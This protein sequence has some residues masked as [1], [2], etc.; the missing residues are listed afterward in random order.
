MTTTRSNLRTGG[1]RPSRRQASRLTTG[2]IALAMAVATVSGSPAGA[3]APV[4]GRAPLMQASAAARVLAAAAPPVG[5]LA[6]S[7]CDRSGATVSCHLWAKPGTTQ[8]LGQPLPIWGFST[9][10]VDPVTAPGP[11]LVLQ[12]GD[13]VT[14][15]LHNRIG[16]PMALVFPGLPKSSLTA[17]FSS[18]AEDQGTPAGTD[19]TYAFTV[20]QPGTFSYEA[21][22]TSNGTRQ[23]AMGLAGAMVVLP[24]N[25]AGAYGTAQTAFD[26][27]A[28]MVLSEIDPRLNAAPAAF[29]MRSFRARYRLINGKAFPTTDPI[30]TAENNT[31][32][33]RYVNV[34]SIP[35]TMGLLGAR[36]T[37]VAQDGHPMTYPESPLM[38]SIEPG[39]TMD[40]MVRMPT[41]PGSKITLYEGGGHLDNNGQTEADPT[42]LAFGGMMTFLDTSAPEPSTDGIGPV[43][44]HV[45]A[46]PNPSDGLTDVTVTADLSDS[47]TGGSN[48][49]AAEFVVDDA[50]TV[51][52]GFGVTMSGSFGGPNAAVSGILPAVPPDPATCVDVHDAALSCLAA[53]KHRIFVRALDSAGNWGVIGATV[54]RLPKLGPTTRDGSLDPAPANG[55]D[56]VTISATGDDGDAEG[57]INQ[58]EYFI[59]TLGDPATGMPLAV[60]RA[61]TVVSLD[62]EIDPATLG[63]LSEGTHHVLVRSHDS[64]GLWGPELDLPLVIDRTGPQVIAVAVMPNPTNGQLD[65]PGNPGNLVVSGQLQDFGSVSNLEDAEGFLVP[66]ANPQ[67][68]SGFQLLPVD[69]NFDSPSEAVYGLIPLEAIASFTDG[70]YNVGIRGLDAAGNWSNLEMAAPPLTVDKQAPTLGSITASPNPTAGASTITVTGSVNEAL[71]GGAEYW[72]GG[73]NTDPGAGNAIPIQLNVVGGVATLAVPVPPLTVGNVRINVRVQDLAGNWSNVSF[74]NVQI[75]TG[76]PGVAGL[77]GFAR[78]IGPVSA[79]TLAGLPRGG[80]NTGALARLVTGRHPKPAYLRSTTKAAVRGFH[81]QVSLSRSALKLSGQAPV[82]VYD[83]RTGKGRPIFTVQV[84]GSRSGA[85]IR[86]LMYRSNGTHLTGDWFRLGS[87]QQRLSVDWVSG[88]AAGAERHGSLKLFLGKHRFFEESADTSRLQMHSIRLG[89]ISPAA[90]AGSGA[91]YF[92]D[93]SSVGQ[94]KR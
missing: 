65:D 63:A 14:V 46:A 80:T 94:T 39:Q 61:A 23:V 20:A 16:Q 88:R 66:D 22:H 76:A 25:P 7:G 44:S 59:D 79:S 84:V 72:I 37:V 11:L 47:T 74:R 27:E 69:G 31:V 35:H 34:G 36:Q 68:G 60:N 67:P 82:T 38:V 13:Q 87:G 10:D 21:G 33:L 15:T 90:R 28:V 1:L 53:G 57:V 86:G 43:P 6:T 42:R 26:D 9:T 3:Q 71:F 45:T 48:V 55:T 29:D 75:T 24:T 32:L 78:A 83:A 56:P 54:F 93:Y 2:L 70:T 40:S 91:A 50:V 81:G 77:L 73:N 4:G 52:V 49:D 5:K 12:Q 30:P 41:G 64:L 85:Q 8:V 18:A 17:G 92:D 89:L 62:G 58:A 51:G 19:T